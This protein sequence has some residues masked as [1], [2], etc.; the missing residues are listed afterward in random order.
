[1]ETITKYPKIILKNDLFHSKKLDIG[2]S[3]ICD[4]R[5]TFELHECKLYGNIKCVK[6]QQINDGQKSYS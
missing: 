4:C 3:K 2:Y 1:M 6:F 5:E